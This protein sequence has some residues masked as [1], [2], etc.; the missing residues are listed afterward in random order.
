LRRGCPHGQGGDSRRAIFSARSEGGRSG[1]GKHA[2]MRSN[3]HVRRLVL[4]QRAEQAQPPERR[5]RRFAL[6]RVAPSP[7]S[8]LGVDRHERLERVVAAE[9]R[10][11]DARP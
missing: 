7:R 9:R 4:V 2:A 10:R 11:I 8:A 3:G 5:V 6:A 1:G